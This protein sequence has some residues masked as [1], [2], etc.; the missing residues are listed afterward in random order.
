MDSNKD[1]GPTEVVMLFVR[2]ANLKGNSKSSNMF[3]AVDPFF[4]VKND[5]HEV[6]ARSA[7][8][9]DDMNPQWPPI[10]LDLEA[11]CKGDQT[12]DITFRFMPGARMANMGYLAK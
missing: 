8:F 12:R 4:E 11:L 1:D 5:E 7:I 3:G 10:R 2:A 6:V 9:R